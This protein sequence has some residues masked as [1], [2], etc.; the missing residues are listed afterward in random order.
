MA[1]PTLRRRLVE[2]AF[3][4]HFQFPEGPEGERPWFVR[5]KGRADR[6][7][8][9]DDG[10]VHVLDYKSGRPPD[11]KV[12]L[13]V[14]LYSACL[15]QQLTAPRVEGSYLSLRERKV[16]PRQDPE[17]VAALLKE[18]YR[19]ITQ[20]RL[21]PRPYQD[22]LCNTCGYVGVCRKEIEEPSRAEAAGGTGS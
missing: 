8:V 21:E 3:Q 18:T 16:V 1:K 15:Q 13:Q 6:V 4:N 12:S 11:V 9:Y 14:P 10:S 5:I 7:D 22:F 2:Y 20:G 19:N 17:G